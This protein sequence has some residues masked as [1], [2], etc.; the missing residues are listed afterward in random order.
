MNDLYGEDSFVC[1]HC[2]VFAQQSWH[3]VQHNN[4]RS[5]DEYG[6]VSVNDDYMIKNGVDYIY[7]NDEYL[8]EV[9]VLAFCI[10]HSCKKP[11]LWY[12]HKLAY[13]FKNT[14]YVEDPNVF[15]PSEVKEL[16]DEAKA[17]LNL[18]PRSSAAL[19]RLALEVLLPHLGA[20]KAKINTMIKQLVDERKVI[21][22]L[23]QA[24]DSLRV[25]G[26]DA[27]HP[28]LIDSEDKD[29]KEVS[30]ALFKVINFIVAETLESDKMIGDLYSLLPEKVIKGIEDRENPPKKK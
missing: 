9:N 14:V 6:M 5:V 2:S 28:G 3:Q 20:E 12:D 13:P 21:G 17:V 1:P 7:H 19:L 30:L 4:D 27:V 29:D 15:M 16:Y 25:I 24:M 23:Q 11:S 22:K 26:N 10:C 8:N 18:S